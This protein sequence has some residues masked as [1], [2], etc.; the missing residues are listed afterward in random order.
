MTKRVSHA[1]APGIL[2]ADFPTFWYPIRVRGTIRISG[3]PDFAEIWIFGRMEHAPMH[4]SRFRCLENYKTWHFE[5]CICFELS[6]CIYAYISLHI[7]IY[8]Y[9]L[10]YRSCRP[11]P[12]GLCPCR[13]HIFPEKSR[14][15]ISGACIL[16]MLS[17]LS[18]CSVPL[19]KNQN[20]VDLL[21]WLC[22]QDA[23]Q[24]PVQKDV[25]HCPTF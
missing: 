6:A 12:R 23:H 8:C 18:D 25:L 17:L 3:F 11:P 22:Q 9:I 13:R 21:K 7:A 19:Q 20:M 16:W 14:P 5:N 1:H 4:I 10:L 24:N 15:W 2:L